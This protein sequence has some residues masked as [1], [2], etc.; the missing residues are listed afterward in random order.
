MSGVESLK[1]EQFTDSSGL[2]MVANATLSMMSRS[3]TASS[4]SIEDEGAGIDLKMIE[5]IT[6]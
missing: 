2:E 6:S 4:P 1:V 5:L 3:M